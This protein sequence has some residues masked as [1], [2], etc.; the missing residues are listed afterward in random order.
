MVCVEA[1]G[2]RHSLCELCCNSAGIACQ[3]QGC[4][5][6]VA[7]PRSHISQDELHTAAP[8]GRL[9][10][11][12]LPVQPAQS[13][14]AQSCAGLKVETSSQGKLIDKHKSSKVRAFMSMYSSA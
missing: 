3:G 5:L 11:V 10:K 1:M 2:G 6:N 13:I 14:L 8:F 12:Q 9:P 4:L 7:L